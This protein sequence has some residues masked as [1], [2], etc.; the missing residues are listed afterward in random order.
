MKYQLQMVMVDL[1]AET[2]IL[3]L[4]LHKKKIDDISYR[5]LH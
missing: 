4:L 5:Q 1:M 3:I 2:K